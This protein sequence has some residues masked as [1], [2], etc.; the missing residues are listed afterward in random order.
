MTDT[1]PEQSDS[2]RDPA[3][4]LRVERSE[5]DKV[6]SG[7]AA[8]IAA[9]LGVPADLMRAA[10]VTL[11]FAGGVGVVAY[12]IAWALS[13]P[14]DGTPADDCIGLRRQAGLGLALL[15]ILLGLREIDLWFGDEVVWPVAFI[16][17]GI[18]AMWSRRPAGRRELF[19]ASGDEGPPMI[20]LIIGAALVIGGSALFL[21]TV[22]ALESLGAVVLAIAITGAGVAL[23]FGPWIW[24]L[25]TDLATERRER[26]RSEERAEMAAHLHD[27]VLQ[28]LSLIQRTDD[29]REMVVLARAQERELRSWLFD[30]PSRG[31]GRLRSVLQ[32]AAYRVEA[33]H[34]IPVEVVAT[35][36]DPVMDDALS[37][38]V[39]AAGEAMTN[40][41]RHSGVGSI[42]LYVE[43]GS[44]SVQAWV[45]DQG[46]GFDRA[47]VA[48]DRKGISESIIARMRRAG[49]TAEIVSEKGE[50]TEVHLTM[51][52][53]S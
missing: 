34:R 44:Q 41:A 17:F 50:G 12:G 49:G 13:V 32:S 8:G 5:A 20:R 18:A 38:L 46:S 3:R 21:S 6:V 40:A 11:S 45:S 42:S 48:G 29:P 4:R 33:D 14:G 39:Q 7:V 1:T 27:S 23:V 9:R 37:A 15:G 36:D 53:S 28:T 22:D 2:D 47:E 35:G 51:R 25:G 30:G 26:I 10:F 19:A 52:R 24:R 16:S 43:A 31:E